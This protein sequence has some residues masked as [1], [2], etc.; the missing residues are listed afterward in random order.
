MGDNRA[1]SRRR[2]LKS[3]WIIFSDKAAKLECTVR[4]LSEAGAS[5]QISTTYGMPSNFALII[6]GVRHSCRIVWRTDTR[7]GVAFLQ[8][9]GRSESL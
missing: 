4:N 1:G 7:L 5:L 6:D 9:A 8:A 3:G 2:V